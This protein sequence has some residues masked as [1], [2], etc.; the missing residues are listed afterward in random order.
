MRFVI[1]V[2]PVEPLAVTSASSS[3]TRVVD[4][5]LLDR[6][7]ERVSGLPEPAHAESGWTGGASGE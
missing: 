1:E 5:E 6:G 4:A 2:R 7:D 3:P